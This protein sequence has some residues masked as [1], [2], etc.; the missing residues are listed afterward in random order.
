L[1]FEPLPARCVCSSWNRAG[2][3]WA[4]NTFGVRRWTGHIGSFSLTRIITDR[5]YDQGSNGAIPLRLNMAREYVFGAA[6]GPMN[7]IRTA[8]TT[9]DN[10][11][12]TCIL[13][14]AKPVLEAASR[15]WSESEYCVDPQS[16]SLR[17][18]SVAPGIYAIYGY[19]NPSDFHGRIVPDQ[20]TIAEA[21]NVVLQGS[22]S[23]KDPESL[24]PVLFTPTS[25]M[26]TGG[27]GLLPPTHH[28][29][30][31]NKNP[32][33]TLVQPVIV[34]AILS[35]DGGVVEAEALQTPDASLSQSAV[36]LVKRTK[37][38]ST[39]DYGYPPQQE[40]FVTVE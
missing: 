22:I 14:S 37:F 34:H 24:D 40:I 30:S 29:L 36:D 20:I 39:T 9:L 18:Y 19:N 25:Q 5:W 3:Q 4:R 12:L 10:A 28:F 23:V 8:N 35:P 26:F 2:A 15:D 6:L 16:G 33:S 7:S 17:V 38:D 1:E 31:S 32:A 27:V 13:T 11:F 21:G